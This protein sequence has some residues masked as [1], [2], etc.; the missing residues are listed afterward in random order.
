MDNRS[1][2]SIQ[3]VC[4]YL[5][6]GTGGLE[7]EADMLLK[8]GYTPLGPAS[9]SGDSENGYAALQTMVMYYEE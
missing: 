3:Y 5:S 7:A 8:Q 1:V 2:K 6:D 9:I 4:H